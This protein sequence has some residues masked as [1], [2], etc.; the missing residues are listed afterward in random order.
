MLI[1]HLLANT[2]KEIIKK[3]H[4]NIERKHSLPTVIPQGP[5]QSILSPS[6]EAKIGKYFQMIF[7]VTSA[8]IQGSSLAQGMGKTQVRQLCQ[9]YPDTRVDGP[10]WVEL[11]T[12]CSSS[13]PKTDIGILTFLFTISLCFENSFHLPRRSLFTFSPFMACPLV[14]RLHISISNHPQHASHY[15]L[16]EILPITKH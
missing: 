7:Q 3:A 4:I 2:C 15:F 13:H 14:F 12:F 9:G 5:P 8:L 1:I 10:F 11:R 6:Q 16:Q